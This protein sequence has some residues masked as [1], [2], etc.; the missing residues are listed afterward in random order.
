MAFI[1]IPLIRMPRTYILGIYVVEGELW[2]RNGLTGVG[3]SKTGYRR[4]N[5]LQKFYRNLLQ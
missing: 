1:L 3:A 2:R 4:Y 5:E